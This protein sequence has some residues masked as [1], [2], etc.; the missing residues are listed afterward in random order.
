[1][2]QKLARE[3]WLGRLEDIANALPAGRPPL[4]LCLIGSAA[5]LL[6]GMPG[7]ASRDGESLLLRNHQAM[8]APDEELI[9]REMLAKCSRIQTFSLV[10]LR[11]AA[12]ATWLLRYVHRGVSRARTRRDRPSPIPRPSRGSHAILSARGRRVGSP[13][14]R[15]PR[16]GRICEGRMIGAT[17]LAFLDF[18]CIALGEYFHDGGSP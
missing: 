10:V 3:E 14:N 11:S 8:T 2:S 4:H 9:A 16:G 15:D 17:L 12:G 6:G 5:R 1:M 7:R 18:P 13:K